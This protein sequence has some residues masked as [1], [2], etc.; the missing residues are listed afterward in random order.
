MKSI[1]A[2][3]AL[4]ISLFAAS[5]FA[6]TATTTSPAPAVSTEVKRDVKQQ[7]R[8]EQGLKSGELNT[9]EAAKLEKEE[10]KV[11]KTEA[12]ALKDGKLNKNERRRINKM[13]DKV[14]SDI[15]AQ[16]HDAQTGNPD[17]VSSKRMQ[18]D[19]QRNVNQEKRI[20]GGVQNGSLTKKEVAKLEN[21]QAKVD[22]TEAKAGAD[23]HVGAAEQ[24]RIQRKEN[25]QSK[26]IHHEKHDA[27]SAG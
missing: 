1:K 2:L 17:S 26:H 4:L 24:K 10:S 22:R 5:A 11:D 23:G 25:R 15:A 13:Q 19:V 7:E 18:A 3:P 8:I 27:Q 14:S 12:A 6:Q 21:G 9:R 16:K 20:E